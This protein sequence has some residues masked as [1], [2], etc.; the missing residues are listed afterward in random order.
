LGAERSFGGGEKEKTTP[1]ITAMEINAKI[2][3]GGNCHGLRNI[4][5]VNF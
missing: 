2:I 3:I 1:P 4:Q 5:Y